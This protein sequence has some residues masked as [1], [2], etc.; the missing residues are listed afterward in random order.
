MSVFFEN[1]PALVVVTPLLMAAVTAV[2]P[3]RLANLAWMLA[4]ASTATSLIAAWL[5]KA[6]AG[7]ERI[8][9]ALGGWPPPWG[10]EFV[11]DGASGLVTVV[12]SSLAFASTIYAKPLIENE[13][14]KG[15]IPRVYA[16]WQLTVGALLGLVMTA[17]AFNLFVFLEISALSAV[18]LIAMGAGKDRR[19]LIAAYNYLVIGAVGAT[20][21][22]MGV[23][24]LYAMTGTLNMADLAE[25]LPDVTSRAPVYV[26]MAFMVAGIFVKAAVFPVH[27]WLPAAYGF[28]PTA[29]SALL[30]AVA[31]KASIYVLGRL[32]FT[33]F[34]DL[35][36]IVDLMLEWVVLPV[37]LM[38]IFVG[39]ILAIWA[40]DLKTLLAQSSI[41]QIGYITLGFGLGTSAGIS[42]GFIHIANHAL[43]KGGMFMAVGA[44]AL[45]LGKRAGIGTIEGFGRLMP[46]TASALTICGLS[47]IGLPLTAG[48]ISKVYLVLAIIASDYWMIAALVLLSS[49][50]SL[51]YLW[52]MMEALWMKPA[53][54][55][56]I[57]KENP[58]VYLPLWLIALANIWFG[59][60]ATLVTS[61]A[62]AAAAALM[63]GAGS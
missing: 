28:A 41:A 34:H 22:V 14:A 12:I 19:A 18:T 62:E 61:S 16:A 17:D 9:Y 36:E 50:L 53:P 63:A 33:V 7:G 15:D 10:I 5:N 56:V 44:I 29:V 42:A 45:A 13:I 47:L 2:M 35:G 51:I 31:T 54:H 60:D 11:T 26:G 25:R 55:G 40:R 37:S 52:K 57:I 20:F 38:A 59:I 6:A 27:M 48:F 46:V 58:A 39:T 49:A 8:S 32:I 3:A 24:F 23:G 21:Y 4:L 1:L 43:I 30:A